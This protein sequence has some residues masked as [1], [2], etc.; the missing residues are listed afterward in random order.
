[1]EGVADFLDRIGPGAQHG[2]GFQDD[3]FPDPIAGMPAGSVIDQFG[4]VFRRDTEFL[5]VIADL[6]FG[7]AMDLHFTEEVLEKVLVPALDERFFIF[8]IHGNPVGKAGSHDPQAAGQCIP[9]ETEFLACANLPDQVVHREQHLDLALLERH[10][11]RPQHIL[12][13]Y[14]EARPVTFAD[15]GGFVETQR[16]TFGARAGA[17]PVN[18][19]AREDQ[20]DVISVEAE[21]FQ[22]DTH[23]DFS[24]RADHQIDEHLLVRRRKRK[25]EQ[26]FFVQRKVGRPHA[27]LIEIVVKDQIVVKR[28]RISGEGNH[29]EMNLLDGSLLCHRI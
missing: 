20:D 12:A 11:Q 19:E 28:Y 21:L 6:A 27:W 23:P 14:V 13:D 24:F 7:R 15:K 22:I 17:H 1:M 18:D 25:S 29:S 5:G 2:L 26:P 10:E 4:K 3:I 9:F 16:S 8:R